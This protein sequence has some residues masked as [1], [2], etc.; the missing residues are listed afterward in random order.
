MPL[1]WIIYAYRNLVS[2]LIFNRDSV[3]FLPAAFSVRTVE[4]L[5]IFGECMLVIALHVAIIAYLQ[6]QVVPVL[7]AYVLPL[8][9][10]Y[11]GFMMYIFTNHLFSPMMDTNDPLANSIS[12][13]VPKLLDILHFNLSYHAEHHIFPALNSDYYPQVRELLRQHFPERMG[14]MLPLSEA[15]RRLL[16]TPNLYLDDTTLTDWSGTLVVPC[17]GPEVTAVISTV[18]AAE[19][20]AENAK[21]I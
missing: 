1:A 6:F 15:W 14:Y 4:R 12:L 16:N 5:R 18:D 9:L 17:P 2:V 21:S 8:A 7:L 11:A 10:G 20:V 3:S 13:K 19:P